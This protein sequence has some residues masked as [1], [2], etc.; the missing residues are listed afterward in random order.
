V[1]K[2]LLGQW[3]TELY[4]LFGIE[5]RQGE[6]DPDSFG[7]TGVF[8]VHREFAGS[9]KGASILKAVHPFDLIVVDEAHEIFAGIYKR[10]DKQGTYNEESREAVSAGRV[11]EIA[12]RAGTPVL[13]L[14]ATPI[15]NSLTGTLGPDPV[16]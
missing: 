5:T 11:R 16:C 7:G 13:L 8:L 3:Q 4:S 14:T 10:Y 1:P 15:Q 6:L 12:Q 2:S 9:T